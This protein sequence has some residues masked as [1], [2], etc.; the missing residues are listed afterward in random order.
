MAEERSAKM[1]EGENR[2]FV[3]L[4]VFP[5]YITNLRHEKVDHDIKFSLCMQIYRT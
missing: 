4:S 2:Q 3:G 5:S 1:Q